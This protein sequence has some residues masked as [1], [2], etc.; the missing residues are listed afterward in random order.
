MGVL[1]A[2]MAFMPPR[3]VVRPL[4]RKEGMHRGEGGRVARRDPHLRAARPINDY[5]RERGMARRHHIGAGHCPAVHSEG[6]SEVPGAEVRG[7]L[8]HVLPDHGDAGA[9]RAVL[10]LQDDAPPVGQVLKDVLRIV[11][12]DAHNSSPTCLDCRESTVGCGG[13]VRAAARRRTAAER[14]E[15]GS[16]SNQSEC[17]W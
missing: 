3:P 12:I 2:R 13:A 14:G 11:L 10:P 15:D 7:H 4:E 9:I 1:V 5:V 16:K 8:P 17:H 6:L